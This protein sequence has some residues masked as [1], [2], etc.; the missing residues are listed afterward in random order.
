MSNQKKQKTDMV[1]VVGVAACILAIVWMFYRNRPSQVAQ[2]D[3][4]EP[5]TVMTTTE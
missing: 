2:K 3:P 5:K 1:S 4:Q